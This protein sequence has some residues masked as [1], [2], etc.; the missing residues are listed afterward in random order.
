M[1]N[2][3]LFGNLGAALVLLGLVW[4]PIGWVLLSITYG[5]LIGAAVFSIGV[6]LIA[7]SSG[8]N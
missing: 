7:T 6:L 4:I 5:L 8:G 3:E 2:P 1:S